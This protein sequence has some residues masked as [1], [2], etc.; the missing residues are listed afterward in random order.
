MKKGG[1][2]VQSLL[3][4]R[5]PKL[6]LA[7]QRESQTFLCAGIYPPRITEH[8]SR[9]TFHGTLVLLCRNQQ[10]L[11][12]RPFAVDPLAIAPESCA[13]R[14]LRNFLG[15]VFVRTF[16]PDGFVFVQHES[17]TGR[18]NV[19]RLTP[20]RAQMHLNPPFYP[21]PACVVLEAA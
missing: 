5:I 14:H 16:R 1:R 21:I 9:N 19:Y 2:G 13:R 11:R 15:F 7:T 12:K 3:L 17:Q 10:V 20:R 6:G 8:R 4:T 18:R